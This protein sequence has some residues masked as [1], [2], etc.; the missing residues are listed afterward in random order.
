MLSKPDS[1][2]LD[3]FSKLIPTV[4]PSPFLTKLNPSPMPT[5]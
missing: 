2:I 5:Q 1:P 4:G 3:P